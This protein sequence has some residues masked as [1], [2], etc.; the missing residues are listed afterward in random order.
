LEPNTPCCT[1]TTLASDQFV[2]SLAGR[3][4]KYWLKH[5]DSPDRLRERCELLL[6]KVRA[7]L[8]LI[9]RNRRYW[10]LL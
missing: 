4:K 6:V 5:A 2:G 9:R 10:D 1:P 7:R 3:S 8:I